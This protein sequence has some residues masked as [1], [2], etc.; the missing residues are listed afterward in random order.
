VPSLIAVL[1]LF[2][3]IL[4]LVLNVI[5]VYNGTGRQ[6]QFESARERCLDDLDALDET[7]LDLQYSNT[8]NR[9]LLTE[10]L[11][12]TKWAEIACFDDELIMD[13]TPLSAE[14]KLRRDRMF[15][16]YVAVG[17][18]GA[19]TDAMRSSV[20]GLNTLVVLSV[21]SSGVQVQA[22]GSPR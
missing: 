5:V 1:A 16:E 22:V 11:A 19:T 7:L 15:G 17:F 8:P 3:A 10:M 2:V 6:A 20:Y 13:G 18:D 9:E 4:S 14:W 21:S 12:K